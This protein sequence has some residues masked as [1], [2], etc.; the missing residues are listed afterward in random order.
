MLTTAALMAMLNG[1]I[2]NG[3][4]TAVSLAISK[5]ITE[6]ATAYQSGEG[7]SPEKAINVFNAVNT[8]VIG[9]F[10]SV[11]AL[12]EDVSL[13]DALDADNAENFNE[14]DLASLDATILTLSSD[15]QY[16]DDIFTL[17]ELAPSWRPYTLML[18]DLKAKTLRTYSNTK[19]SVI[20]FREMVRQFLDRQQESTHDEIDFSPL[21]LAEFD[22]LI[23]TT[24]NEM[25]VG[26]E[27]WQ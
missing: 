17:A 2:N 11:N 13:I 15:I 10:D 12:I 24:H 25:L 3:E 19:A 5:K 23:S 7:M 8:H 22:S 16:L 4:T 1:I 20:Y 6:S 26:G 9:L 14:S 27:K 18:R 21:E